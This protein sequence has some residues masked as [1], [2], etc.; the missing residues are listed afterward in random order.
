MEFLCLGS[1]S[2]GNS[3]F[4]KTANNGI[5]I[6]AGIGI[7][8][9]KKTLAEKGYSVSDIDA[10][11]VTHDHADHIK[12]LG[13]MANDYG[14]LI[15]ATREVHAGI[16]R[17]Y[18]VTEKL[19]PTHQREI[20]KGVATQIG[21]FRVTPFEVSHDSTDCVGYSVQV[22][23]T[24]FCIATD[25]GA[26]TPNVEAAI[27]EANYLV[28][29]ANHDETMLAN[30]AY[31]QYLKERI[32]SARGHLSNRQCAEAIANFATSK[33]RHVWL[34]HLSEDNN[35]PVLAQKTIDQILRSH[36]IVIGAGFRLDVLKRRTPSAVYQLA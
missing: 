5:L 11:F 29:E 18:C 8:T 22:G 31:P 3:Y 15:Y 27:A 30:G 32:S 21:D 1:G 28:I 33:L 34:C 9:I 36:G 26:V 17:N 20:A 13:Q 4:L 6:D 14:K 2:S 23:D 16:N 19:T 35:H 25:C 10:V 12:A 7:R 24:T